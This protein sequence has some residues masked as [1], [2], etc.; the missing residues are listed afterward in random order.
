MKSHLSPEDGGNAPRLQT[1]KTTG[2]EEEANN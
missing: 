2:E 1:S